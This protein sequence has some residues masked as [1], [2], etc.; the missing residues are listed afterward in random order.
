[1][2]SSDCCGVNDEAPG[3]AR[4]DA[5]MKFGVQPSTPCQSPVTWAIPVARASSIS[6]CRSAR[7]NYDEKRPSVATVRII[8][9]QRA[10]T[11]KR[12]PLCRLNV[13]MRAHCSV[14]L[15]PELVKA[16]E[17]PSHECAFAREVLKQNAMAS[18]TTLS[19][20]SKCETS[21]RFLTHGLM[22]A[23]YANQRRAGNS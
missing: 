1:M 14:T 12:R 3:R 9:G 5:A 18:L 23:K 15:C 6:N 11:L 16:Y 20:R 22:R 4:V 13:E 8:S 21:P 2:R 17:H 7:P 10:A 19:A